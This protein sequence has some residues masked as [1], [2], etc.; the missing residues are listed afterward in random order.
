MV[1]TRPD[2]K[3]KNDEVRVY[4][5]GAP[6]VLF[7]YVSHVLDGD[8]QRVSADA[9]GRAAEDLWDLPGMPQ[10]AEKKGMTTQ[11]DTYRRTVKLFADQAYRTIL[12]AY[13]DMSMAEYRQLEKDHNM[14]A[15]EAD[16]QDALECDLTAYGLFGLQDPLR[17][18]I[19]AS[20]QSCRRS[21]IKVIMC[22]GDNIDTA[23]AISR[24]A[25]I[26]KKEPKSDYAAMV[27]ADFREKVGT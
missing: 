24:E 11:L 12:V 2:R 17:P 22:T 26:L 15:K 5:K 9:E 3:G 21:H 19:K 1:V 14:F 6:D 8:G 20:I 23:S 10:L 13:R 16:R 18:E 27:G 25:G 4:T 7:D